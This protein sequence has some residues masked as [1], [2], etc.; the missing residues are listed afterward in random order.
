MSP[1][2]NPETDPAESSG[3]NADP[4]VTSAGPTPEPDAT[5]SDEP[6][7]GTSEPDP[8]FADTGISTGA[9]SG[10][11]DETEPADAAEV[12]VDCPSCGATVPAVT[13]CEECGARLDEEPDDTLTPVRGMPLPCPQCGC[14]SFADGYCDQ[15]GG[16][17]PQ[18][19]DHLE[20]APTAW[21]AGVCD[22]GV[23]HTRNEDSQ[24]M[25]ASTEPG[26]F[27]ALVVCDGVSSVPRSDE[28]SQAA[29]RAAV[30]VLGPPRAAFSETSGEAPATSEP[31]WAVLL[32]AAARAGNDA[33][34]QVAGPAE[35]SGHNCPSCT[36]VAAVVD[37]GR[38]AAAS[39]GD[40]RAYWLPDSGTASALT[41]DDS[42]AQEMIAAGMTREQAERA[43]QAHA[44][45][46]WLGPDAPPVDPPVTFCEPDG[47]G[48]L[49]V[50][51]DG[52]WNYCSEADD[53]SRL[54]HEQ[55]TAHGDDPLDTARA[56]VDWVNARGGRD[57]VTVVLARLGSP[58]R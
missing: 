18:P 28:A 29:A 14:T 52:L 32:V 49:C 21:V 11:P 37:S 58:T 36:F 25:V 12:P 16:R 42:W 57:N 22:R 51:S 7:S 30:T 40:S 35:L 43:P 1:Q 33:V 5:E 55:A 2:T 31:D 38:I 13:F 8:S 9:Q 45:T 54:V 41:T 20:E 6:G 48:W 39:V 17:A 50:C 23:T 47:P 10:E 26:R 3:G 53:L 24:A 27:A 46:R 19:R 4:D 44:I 34:A 56:L 15:C